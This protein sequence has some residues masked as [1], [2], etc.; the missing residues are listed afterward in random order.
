MC[1]FFFYLSKVMKKSK[2]SRHSPSSQNNSP[3]LPRKN[4]DQATANLGL[5]PLD[6]MA[7]DL[8]ENNVSVLSTSDRSRLRS[9]SYGAT[10]DHG[11]ETI[12]ADSMRSNSSHGVIENR[13]S[14]CYTHILQKERQREGGM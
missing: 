5:S 6:S 14:D 12:P 7:A 3:V 2:F 11:Y 13:K 8:L 4:D 10:K 9:N 1:F